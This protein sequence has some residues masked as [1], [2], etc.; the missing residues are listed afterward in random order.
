MSYYSEPDSHN[1]SKT[2]IELD[3]SNYTETSGVEKR[4]GFDTSEFAKKIDLLSL[5]S[6]VDK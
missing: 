1:K 3:L 5:K 4:T 2:K 6:D